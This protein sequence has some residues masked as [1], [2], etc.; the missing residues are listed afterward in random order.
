MLHL[1]Q[2]YDFPLKQSKA[3]KREIYQTQFGLDILQSVAVSP[4][5]VVYFALDN[6]ALSLFT[7]SNDESMCFVQFKDSINNIAI[8]WITDN[9][10]LTL[11]GDYGRVK[12]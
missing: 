12:L 1:I 10:Y 3:E 7:I 8:D 2:I 6:P 5:H 9:I 11:E 4:K